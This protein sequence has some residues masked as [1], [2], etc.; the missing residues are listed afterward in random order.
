MSSKVHLS[1]Y[2][3]WLK[4]CLYWFFIVL[5]GIALHHR[6]LRRR[7]RTDG[8]YRPALGKYPGKKGPWSEIIGAIVP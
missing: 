3:S 5:A 8:V 2:P 7:P 4:N 1:K 6:V